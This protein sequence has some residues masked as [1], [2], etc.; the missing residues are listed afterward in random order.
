M[1]S[2][3]LGL[4]S[5]NIAGNVDA[6]RSH[7]YIFGSATTQFCCWHPLHNQKSKVSTNIQQ[8]ETLFTAASLAGA[9]TVAPATRHGVIT[10]K[11][12]SSSTVSLAT[13]FVPTPLRFDWVQP[14]HVGF[15]QKPG[16]VSH[17][18]GRGGWSKSLIKKHMKILYGIGMDS[19]DCCLYELSPNF[20]FVTKI[21]NIKTRGYTIYF[22][23]GHFLYSF[24]SSFPWTSYD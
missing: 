16:E 3:L 7:R 14:V 9:S 24:N 4:S 22:D 12:S 8:E 5:P 17:W 13:C 20:L 15:P 19:V 6:M 2:W 1:L 23:K 18:R 10:D 11:P 21:D